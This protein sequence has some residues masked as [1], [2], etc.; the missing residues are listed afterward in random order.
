VKGK[1]KEKKLRVGRWISKNPLLYLYIQFLLRKIK[2]FHSI[3]DLR[4]YE[5]V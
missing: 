1:N 3:H 5:I 2:P 4:A